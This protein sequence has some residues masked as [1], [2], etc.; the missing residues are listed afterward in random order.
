MNPVP[1][2]QT[3]PGAVTLVAYLLSSL[4]WR[5]SLPLRRVPAG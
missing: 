5:D 4:A 3:L 1:T 2:L